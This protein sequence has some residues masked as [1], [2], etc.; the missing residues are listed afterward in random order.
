MAYRDCHRAGSVADF[1]LCG[2]GGYALKCIAML[3]NRHAAR[4]AISRKKVFP[5]RDMPRAERRD[6]SQFAIGTSARRRNSIQVQ[7]RGSE[8]AP[9]VA[10]ALAA[11]NPRRQASALPATPMLRKF[12]ADT[13]AARRRHRPR[14]TSARSRRRCKS[15]TRPLDR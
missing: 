1:S 11:A 8:C 9:T 6:A 14:W 10:G 15:A 4:S 12:P 2:C 3:A 13:S 7:V 5:R